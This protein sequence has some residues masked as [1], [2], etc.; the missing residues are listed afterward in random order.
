MPK[1]LQKMRLWGVIYDLQKKGS[2]P[3]KVCCSNCL[4]VPQRLIVHGSTGSQAPEW[5]DRT[6][7]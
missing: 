7:T 2:I 1:D 5:I 6:I 3:Y 4:K